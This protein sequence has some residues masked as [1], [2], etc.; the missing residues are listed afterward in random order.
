[1]TNKD[2]IDKG[3]V[4]EDFWQGSK[5]VFHTEN[6]DGKWKAKL[7]LED[8]KSR[9][10]A[11]FVAGEKGESIDDVWGRVIVGLKE[12]NWKFSL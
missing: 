12:R 11:Y 10:L 7:F 5:P 4:L 3:L 8:N 9:M 1:M 6:V 2:I